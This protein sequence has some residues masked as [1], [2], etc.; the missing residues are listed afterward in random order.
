[1]EGPFNGNHSG[2]IQMTYQKMYLEDVTFEKS[3]GKNKKV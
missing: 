1:M 3:I 2:T